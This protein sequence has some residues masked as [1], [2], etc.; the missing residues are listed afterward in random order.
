MQQLKCLED[1]APGGERLEDR[2]P[3]GERGSACDTIRYDTYRASAAAASRSSNVRQR[4]VKE[5]WSTSLSLR[6]SL[7]RRMSCVNRF[8]PKTWR[9]LNVMPAELCAPPE[10][11][12]GRAAGG[13]RAAADVTRAAL[14]RTFASLRAKQALMGEFAIFRPAVQAAAE[15]GARPRSCLPRR[16]CRPSWRDLLR[17]RHSISH[18]RSGNPKKQTPSFHHKREARRSS[19]MTERGGRKRVICWRLLFPR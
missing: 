2:A 12:R 6:G 15:P 4:S 11:E 3:G 9:R 19:L 1:R 13:A 14:D 10:L 17:F 8:Y 7:R 18:L 16:R 5:L